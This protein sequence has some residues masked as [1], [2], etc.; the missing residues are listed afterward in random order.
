MKSNGMKRLALVLTLLTAG[1]SIMQ[2]FKV[3]AA[4][5]PERITDEKL[6]TI[7]AAENGSV[8]FVDSEEASK[9]YKEGELCEF[10]VKPNDG[11]TVKNVT[12]ASADQEV[13]TSL[14]D[15]IYSF[16][17][18]EDISITAEFEK[19]EE[20]S[21]ESETTV[22][23]ETDAEIFESGLEYH[24]GLSYANTTSAHFTI[25]GN[26]VF[27]ME[28]GVTAPPS[29]TAWTA[30]TY[31]NE[32]IRK[33][34]YYGW[35]GKEPWNGFEGNENKG[36]VLTSLALSHYFSGTPEDVST[37]YYASMG[38]KDFMDYCAAQ[39]LPDDLSQKFNAII[40][41]MP[42]NYQTLVGWEIISIASDLEDVSVEEE[43]FL[44]KEETDNLQDF[45]ELNLYCQ[46]K[47]MNYGMSRAADSLTVNLQVGTHDGGD[48]LYLSDGTTAYC[49]EP[50]AK[51]PDAGNY[52]ATESNDGLL[53]AVTY[54]GY[55]GPGYMEASGFYNLASEGDRQYA[56][57]LT[58]MM[59]S[60]IYDG[61]SDDTDSFE[62]LS[63][64]TIQ[65]LKQM[66]TVM[67][68]NADS[69]PSNY[70]VYTINTGS[71]QTVGF[72][73]FVPQ[74]KLKL[75]KTSANPAITD[76]NSCYSL[77]GAEYGVYSEEA[78]T[79]QVATLTTD[80]TGNSN[81]TDLDAGDYWVKEV[82][83]PKGFALDTQVYKVSV[84][85]GQTATLNVT[86]I[87]Q[88]DPVFILLGKIDKD[89]NTNKP[90]GSASLAGAEFTVRYYDGL[91]DTDPA[92]QGKAAIR[93]WVL[94]TDEDGFCRLAD[95]YKMAGDEF[96]YNETSNPTL[97]LGTITIQE[98]KAPEG[99]LINNEIFVRQITSE[100]NLGT[101]N[102]YNQPT[103]PESVIK[104]GVKIQ[105]RD[106]DTKDASAQGMATL[107]GAEVSIINRSKNAVYV[108]GASYEPGQ[109]VMTITTDTSG[110]AQTTADALPKGDYRAK[111]TKAP[112]GYQLSGVLEQDFS[113]TQN[114]VIVD[115]TDK[116]HSMQDPVI[117]GGVMI[118]KRD[119]ETGAA[120]PTGGA[121]FEGAE[122]AIYN[123]SKLPVFVNGKLYA[124]DA[125]V[126]T[127]TTNRVGL[128]QT[129]PED[130]PCGDYSIVEIKAPE[131]YLLEGV[132]QQDF[133]IRENGVMVDLTSESKSSK[134]YVVRGDIELAKFATDSNNTEDTTAQPLPGIIFSV[135]SLTD[136]QPRYLVTNE[137]GYANSRTDKVY[138]RIKEDAE[139]N[140]MV[141]PDSVI[142]NNT[143]GNFPKDKYV[144]K[145][146]NTPPGYM[147]IKDITF[148]VTSQSYLYQWILNDRDVVSAL[149]V[150]K[151]DEGT[152]K[153]IPIAGT[154]F[155]LYDENME[156]IQMVTSRYP[157]IQYAEEFMTDESGS[158]LLPEKLQ[159]GTYYL[160][161]VVPPVGYLKG[162]ILKFEIE[163][164]HDWSDPLTITYANRPAMGRLR[165]VKTDSVTH[166]PVEGAK[167]GIFAKGDVVT[168][169][170]TIRYADK[171][172]VD[173]IVTGADGSAIT[174]DI[175]LGK[176]EVQ[177]IEVP[178]GY[179]LDTKRYTVDLVYKDGETALVT[180]M[181][182]VEDDPNIIYIR[183]VDGLSGQALPGAELQLLDQDRNVVDEWTSG[184][185][186]HAIVHIMPGTYTLHEKKAPEGYLK[187]EDM[188]I[189][190]AQGGIVEDPF[191]M[192]DDP[193]KVVINKIDATSGESIAGA[194]LQ[195]LDQDQ[196][197]V[198]EWVTDGKEHQLYAI[199]PG[200]YTLHEEE[201][202]KGYVQA[203]DMEIVIEE[204]AEIQS[205]VM[206]DKRIG[207]IFTSMPTYYNPR[208]A[209]IPDDGTI[210]EIFLKTGDDT[211]M[212]LC[213]LAML[214]SG[215]ALLAVKARKKRK[216]AVKKANIFLLLLV[217]LVVGN[218][219]LSYAADL[220]EIHEYTTRNQDEE[221]K[222]FENT[223]EKDGKEYELSGISYEIKEKQ[224][225]KEKVVKTH[226]VTSEAVPVTAEYI[227]E[228]TIT[229]DGIT[230]QLNDCT[231]LAGSEYIQTYT[232]EVE[233]LDTD[234]IPERRL[235]TIKDA[236][237]NEQQID[238]ELSNKVS[239]ASGQWF[240]TTLS[241]TFSNYD[242]GV[243]E[244]QGHTIIAQDSAQPLMGYEAEL[245]QSVGADPSSNR[246]TSTQWA[247]D[248]YTVDGI[249]YRDAVAY[250]QYF[251]PYVRATY[252]GTVTYLQYE[253]NYA[254][255][256]EQDSNTDYDYTIIASAN[257]M[258]KTV[259]IGKIIAVIS[260]G[261]AAIALLA[262]V[263]LLLL[264]KQKKQK[265]STET[266]KHLPEKEGSNQKWQRLSKI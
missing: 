202:P 114:G 61:C 194:K 23:T 237:G 225:V 81:S 181:L 113:I 146:L 82:T 69:I 174:K 7:E 209:N 118:Q 215:A 80:A 175:Y 203:E 20:S 179:G 139:G 101:V 254:A 28:Q 138:S 41:H 233:Y 235:I 39:Q 25:N 262:V 125:L 75:I 220:T 178:H 44:E 252:T 211:N 226:T 91:Y 206:E 232:Q 265:K 256:V 119:M 177:E 54:Y 242:S 234:Q 26:S 204:T 160:E 260:I 243:F 48:S 3:Y 36:V 166:E 34:L 35:Q 94:K 8:S 57:V 165:I 147:P 224:P 88:A 43:S 137:N 131:G 13:E 163:D 164:G 47:A 261:V 229:E 37:S 241:I 228:E 56:Y 31:D 172:L 53:R 155:R 231:A 144:I 14:E 21:S 219:S 151:V 201:V 149:R 180:Q 207:A 123:K 30:E 70:Q 51:L 205:F 236:Q 99:Y 186:D 104:G 199:R 217:M 76:G 140:L 12:A 124:K 45:E 22:E 116:A 167:Y 223:I 246:I 183:K 87:P 65:K 158:F 249:I 173:T 105:K 238:G 230:Y 55:G 222:D 112:E 162:E 240:D 142:P 33:I 210:G 192:I 191:V 63:E 218:Y 4:E 257:Y 59:L 103:I 185:N 255:E 134:D 78:C 258:E 46:T 24:G 29:G 72:G 109:T 141:D 79:N 19:M 168:G 135:T 182:E 108:N 130:L 132:L 193:V 86:D 127:I 42:D 66:I 92:A 95:T 52:T 93:T 89:T 161:E 71:T 190:Y 244:W 157:S 197:V 115:L 6:V 239:L 62:G 198:E 38:L 259:S 10:N 73:R 74:G 102:T 248:P 170:G 176:Y 264:A 67:G 212:L 40:Y 84:A 253:A 49:L 143:R 111:E 97:P 5:L 152:G 200:T 148:E 221:Y 1:I 216:I 250:V 150:E 2:P 110:I 214:L 184:V 90:Q 153:V 120:T 85:S 122:F 188:V 11:Y 83:A 196:N 145:E 60:F 100:G 64:D 154:T 50:S 32:D 16:L 227:P 15:G 17:V 187:A 121:T 189:E 133:S 263:I 58:H 171:E 68:N 159:T 213:L 117:R 18:T 107:A 9:S 195:L 77:N 106:Y 245:L 251:V 96:Y 129:T 266:M 128:A 156:K 208:V 27:G 136:Q 98:T 247:G 169:D 126:M